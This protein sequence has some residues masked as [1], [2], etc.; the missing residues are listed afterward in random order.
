MIR[1]G[2]KNDPSPDHRPPRLHR[3]ARKNDPMVAPRDRTIGQRFAPRHAPALELLAVHE[4]REPAAHRRTR[5]RRAVTRP[6]HRVAQL[7]KRHVRPAGRAPAARPEELFPHHPHRSGPLIEVGRKCSL[8]GLRFVRHGTPRGGGDQLRPKGHGSRAQ[9]PAGGQCTSSRGEGALAAR[10]TR[11]EP[12]RPRGFALRRRVVP[13]KKGTRSPS[14][15]S[16]CPGRGSSFLAQASTPPRV[17][18]SAL[19]ALWPTWLASRT[20]GSCGA[21]PSC[22]QLDLG[23]E[24]VE[25]QHVEHAL[26]WTTKR[27]KH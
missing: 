2:I 7:A 6:G 9:T 10:G 24:F 15:D 8:E 1:G 23:D 27:R 11:P 12:V 14:L 19:C 21:N 17:T 20:G 26:T 3:L 25:R 13:L 22:L 18:S 16:S 4:P 5:A